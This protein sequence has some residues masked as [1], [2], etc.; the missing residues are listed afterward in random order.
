M[1]STKDFW[2]R[3]APTFQN[4]SGEIEADNQVS[5]KV[6]TTKEQMYIRIPTTTPHTPPLPENM[7]E[8]RRSKN[9]DLA[10]LVEHSPWVRAMLPSEG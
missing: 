10:V 9:Q 3:I 6:I 4:E 5:S 2:T 7:K 1:T 8:L